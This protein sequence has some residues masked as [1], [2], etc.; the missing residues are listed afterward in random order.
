MTSTPEKFEFGREISAN[1]S[2]GITNFE[3]FSIG[4]KNGTFEHITGEVRSYNFS[5]PEMN[6]QIIGASL[7]V[8]IGVD[9]SINYNVTRVADK[10]LKIWKE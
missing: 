3:N 9:F 10:I 4:G 1:Y 5:E 8:I 7:Y 6:V 2:V